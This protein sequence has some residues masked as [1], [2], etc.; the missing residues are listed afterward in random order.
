MS[1]QVLGARAVIGTESWLARRMYGQYRDVTSLGF[2]RSVLELEIC[3][4]SKH[5]PHHEKRQNANEPPRVTRRHIDVSV[6]A[7]PMTRE[8]E[9][10]VSH[11][12]HGSEPKAYGDTERERST[13]ESLDNGEEHKA[14]AD[15]DCDPNGPAE[16]AARSFSDRFQHFISAPDDVNQQ[17]RNEERGDDPRGGE[18][19][20]GQAPAAP[21]HQQRPEVMRNQCKDSE[22]QQERQT[23]RECHA[24]QCR[25]TTAARA[26]PQ[27][28]WLGGQLE[29]DYRHVGRPYP[30]ALLFA[31]PD[32][33][34]RGATAEVC[35]L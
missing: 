35:R 25:S 24:S 28:H 8:V 4:C 32:D 27:E 16:S 21:L 34:A 22:D 26:N 29:A 2:A 23:E 11:E 12:H 15:D 3:N 6:R 31:R 1:D 7:H 5:G 13:S 17:D 33:V 18:Q 14:D 19:L 10:E 30:L 9:K 20:G